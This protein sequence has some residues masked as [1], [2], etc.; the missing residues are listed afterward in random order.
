MVTLEIIVQVQCCRNVS[1]IG[2]RKLMKYSDFPANPPGV[3]LNL[4]F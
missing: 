1:T 3:G 4:P 2:P